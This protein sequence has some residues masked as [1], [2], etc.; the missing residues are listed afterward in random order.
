MCLL[1]ALP[2]SVCPRSTPYAVAA[3]S[4]LGDRSSMAPS[5]CS[6]CMPNAH[7]PTAAPLTSSRSSAKGAMAA[8]PALPTLL[9]WPCELGP[10]CPAIAPNR[11]SVTALVLHRAVSANTLSAILAS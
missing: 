3:D 1:P 11:H 9:H 5:P 2:L 8:M 10:S 6:Q 4:G 7:P